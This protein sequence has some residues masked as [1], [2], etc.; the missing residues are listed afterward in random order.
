MASSGNFATFNPLK[1]KASSYTTSN[2]DNAN[3]SL[4]STTGN[5]AQLNVGFKNGDG[6]FYFEVYGVTIPS[7]LHYGVCIDNADLNNVTAG[8]ATLDRDWETNI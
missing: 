5:A 7:S 6:K 2:I 8:K 4:G 1:Y 3:Q